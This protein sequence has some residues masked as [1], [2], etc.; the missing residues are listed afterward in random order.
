[1]T[2]KQFA[3][4]A[5]SENTYVVY[6]ETR[7]CIIIDPGC[8]DQSE[9]DE[10]KKFIL[11]NKLIVKALI[12]THCHIDHVLGNNFVKNEYGVGLTIHKLD[13]E[14]LKANEMVAPI[15]GFHAYE[16]TEADLF[17]DE[18]EQVKFGN[19]V[20]DVLFVPGHAPGHIALV[21]ATENICIAGD[22]LFQGSI[23]RTDL[24]GGDFDTLM[25]SIKNKLFTLSDEVTV[26]C[27]HG[28]STSI[29]Y[30]KQYNPFCGAGAN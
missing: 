22:V 27:G 15:Y 26:Y 21:N 1:M 19:S 13:I 23:G 10:L 4:N 29:G 2:I 3:F 11:E 28:P 6:D 7:D 8:F 12:N 5:L 30:E 9:K 18:G 16:T 24:P 14:T 25:K 17:I 20:L